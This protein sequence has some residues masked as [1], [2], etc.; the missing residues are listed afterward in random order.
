MVTASNGSGNNAADTVRRS[1]FEFAP[2]WCRMVPPSQDRWRN[3]VVWTTRF[4]HRA[5]THSSPD[6]SALATDRARHDEQM[7]I[8]VGL[9]L[10]PPGFLDGRPADQKLLRDVVV[11]TVQRLWPLDRRRR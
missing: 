8:P 11:A 5:P 3:S 10:R 7:R 4:V 2:P 9:Q 6:E 1:S